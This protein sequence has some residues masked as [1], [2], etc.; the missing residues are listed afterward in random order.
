MNKIPYEHI[1]TET[2]AVSPISQLPQVKVNGKEIPFSSQLT[3]EIAKVFEKETIE[4]AVLDNGSQRAFE[5][6]I[7]G[8]LNWVLI[9]MRANQ[10]NQLPSH[11]VFQ[12]R[13][14]P[15]LRPLANKVVTNKLKTKADYQGIG[16]QSAADVWATGKED[17]RAISAYLGTKDYLAGEQPNK[18]DATAFAYLCQFYYAPAENELKTFI[19][20]QCPN[21]VA[22]LERMKHRFWP[23]WDEKLR[24]PTPP[25]EKT[26]RKSTSTK[27]EQANAGAVVVVATGEQG[28][29]TQEN[30]NEIKDTTIAVNGET[31]VV[32]TK[33][34][35]VEIVKMTTPIITTT[36]T[37]GGGGDEKEKIPIAV[38]A[39]ENGIN[40]EINKTPNGGEIV[41]Q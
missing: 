31:P 32:E 25:K 26:S 2:L 34:E 36:N 7:E 11:D 28:G 40:E 8:S 27:D 12:G 5:G 30:G 14:W 6:L 4:T 41:A 33:I 39:L 9:Y 15:F 22:Y 35:T 29:E 23:D 19:K 10:T 37:I 17:L 16:R 38:E 3:N 21:L 18:L 13:L 24:K 20:E 1:D